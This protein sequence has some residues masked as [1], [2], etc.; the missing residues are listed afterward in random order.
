MK[1]RAKLVLEWERRLEEQRGQVNLSELCREF[2]VSRP[3]GCR[4]IGRYTSDGCDIRRL[5]ERSRR[6]R[7]SPTAVSPEM[8]DVVVAG[9]LDD[10]H[11]E[12]G[13]ARPSRPRREHINS[14]TLSLAGDWA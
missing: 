12:R 6:P 5:E 11:P 9:Y 7:R 4:W 1:E 10:A 14:A 13:L 3:T 2:G 8:E